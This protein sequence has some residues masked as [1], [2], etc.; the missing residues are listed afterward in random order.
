MGSGVCRSAAATIWVAG[1]ERNGFFLDGHA[2]DGRRHDTEVA[3]VGVHLM[4]LPMKNHAWT[5]APL[6]GGGYF[7][8]IT[9]VNGSATFTP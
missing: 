8:R 6:N 7:V 3:F 5:I 1:S 2:K 9:G 4:L